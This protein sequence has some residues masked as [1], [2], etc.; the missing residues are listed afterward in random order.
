MNTIFENE[1]IQKSIMSNTN[2]TSNLILSNLR[3]ENMYGKILE[4]KV[5]QK[6]EYVRSKKSDIRLVHLIS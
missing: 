1:V 2:C 4:N 6:S 5:I 3:R